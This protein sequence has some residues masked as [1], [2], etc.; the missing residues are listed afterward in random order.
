MLFDWDHILYEWGCK[1]SHLKSKNVIIVVKLRVERNFKTF[2]YVHATRIK[3]EQHIN[4]HNNRH[5][6]I[7]SAI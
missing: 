6:V 3:W 7:Y 2:A 1:C 4:V 5:S